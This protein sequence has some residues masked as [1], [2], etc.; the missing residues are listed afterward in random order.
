MSLSF[1]FY[2]HQVPYPSLNLMKVYR[3]E[4]Q[5]FYKAVYFPSYRIVSFLVM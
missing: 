4:R 5:R 2:A 1:P 3:L